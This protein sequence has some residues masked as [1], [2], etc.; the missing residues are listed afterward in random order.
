MGF[1]ENN[2]FYDYETEGSPC[3]LSTYG[4]R[5]NLLF[6]LVLKNPNCL[7]VLFQFSRC[8]CKQTNCNVVFG[9]A[10]SC[11]YG[12]P[13]YIKVHHAAWLRI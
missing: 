7:S 13:T 5:L 11:F 12:V 6:R 9:S 1:R 8:Q 3:I 10:N 4:D 2:S